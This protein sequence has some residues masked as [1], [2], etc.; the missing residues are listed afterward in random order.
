VAYTYGSS[1]KKVIGRKI[2]VKLALSKKCE[3]LSKTYLKN[4]KGLGRE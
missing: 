2:M 3:V 4:K 1:C